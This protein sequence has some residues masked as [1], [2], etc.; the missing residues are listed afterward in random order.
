MSKYVVVDSDILVQTM[1]K[2]FGVTKEQATAAL[3]VTVSKLPRHDPVCG[4]DPYM[5]SVCEARVQALKNDLHDIQKLLTP[6]K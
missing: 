5:A 1:M 6:C 3:N 2:G 4:T